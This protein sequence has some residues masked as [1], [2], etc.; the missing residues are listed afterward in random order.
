MS[1]TKTNQKTFRLPRRLPFSVIQEDYENGTPR[2]PGRC[3]LAIAIKRE[4][5]AKGCPTDSRVLVRVNGT[6]VTVN[7]YRNYAKT[8][9]HAAFAVFGY[10]GETIEGE[11]MKYEPFTATLV[12]TDKIKVPVISRVEQERKNNYSTRH[13]KELREKGVKPKKYGRIKG[14]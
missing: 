2:S 7:G 6:T 10:D 1:N 4:L 8:P 3:A 13:R 14:L 9:R 11:P 5:L 12:F